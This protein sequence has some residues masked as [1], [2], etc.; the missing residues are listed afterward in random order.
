MFSI[1]SDFDGTL[2]D[3]DTIDLLVETFLGSELK[4]SISERLHA[5]R[6]TIREAL[7]EEFSQLRCSPESMRDFLRA[8][9]RLD[10]SLPRLIQFAR[11]RGYPFTVLSSGMDLL[12]EPLLEAAGCNINV[13]CNRLNWQTR[14]GSEQA[15]F[16][17]EFIDDSEHGHDK[18]RSLRQARAAGY[19][20][21]YIG[22]GLSDI[23]CAREADTLF[24]RRTLERYCRDHGIPFEHLDSCDD[25]IRWLEKAHFTAEHAKDAE[26]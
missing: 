7:S 19:R 22:D 9:V 15:S 12:I 20:V 6:M 24:A 8:N 1:F 16:S 23:P 25:V 10:P 13:R 14:N 26:K 2:T 21:I 4:R 11:E 18:A 17:I 5:G 3:R